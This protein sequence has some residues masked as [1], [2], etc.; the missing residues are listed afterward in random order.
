MLAVYGQ[1]LTNSAATGV[2]GFTGSEWAILHTLSPLPALPVDTTN[3][4]RAAF[5]RFG[6]TR[7]LV[8]NG[9]FHLLVGGPKWLDPANPARPA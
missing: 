2:D 4:Y 6:I 3:K 7:D 5:A 8:F 9:E 1:T